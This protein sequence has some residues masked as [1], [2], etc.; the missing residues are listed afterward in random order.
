MA[1]FDDLRDMAT[2]LI[3]EYGQTATLRSVSVSGNGPGRREE[4]TET[5]ITVVDNGISNMLNQ[6]GIPELS[7]SLDMRV[8]AGVVPTVE[9][10][11]VLQSGE[12]LKIIRVQP[13]SPSGEVVMYRLRVEA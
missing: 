7:R 2:D 5:T 10:S 1:D 6:N 8:E 3:T 12:V 11:V 4:M 13:T 9:D